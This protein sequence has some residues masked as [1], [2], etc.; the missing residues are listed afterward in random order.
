MATPFLDLRWLKWLISSFISV[1]LYLFP[2]P[3]LLLTALCSA[4]SSVM[5]FLSFPPISFFMTYFA[6][7]VWSALSLSHVTPW[8]LLVVLRF[9]RGP[10][11]EPLASASLRSLT[12]KVLFLVSLATA[13]RVGEL[14]AMSR[15]VSF[16]GSDAYLSYLPR[17]FCVQSLEDFVSDLPGELLIC[18]VC[19]LRLY[20]YRTASISPRPCFLFVSPRSPFRSLSKNALSFFLRDV[21]SNAYSSSSPAPPFTSGSS[22]APSFRRLIVCVGLL[23]RELLC[24]IPLFPPLLLRRRGLQLRSS[25]PISLKFSFLLLMVLV[26]VLW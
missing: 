12:Q 13:R 4:V 24:V 20:L 2:T 6:L 23:L 10:P 26:W 11:F 17:S 9:L 1:A 8:D 18:P 16:S 3:L 22:S 7:F 21:I 19:A 5:F 25:P 15:E 14:Q